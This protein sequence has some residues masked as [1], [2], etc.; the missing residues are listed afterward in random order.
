MGTAC[1]NDLTNNP[2]RCN[3]SAES[4][5]NLRSPDR[6]IHRGRLAVLMLALAIHGTLSLA[7]PDGIAAFSIATVAH[8]QQQEAPAEGENGAASQD[9]AEADGNGN[10]GKL[11]TLPPAYEDQL[12]RL[13]EVLGALHYLRNLCGSEE[14]QKWREEMQQLIDAEQP[15]E[16]S[17]AQMI[18]RFNRG[19]RGYAEIHH[20]CNQA[21]VE[22]ANDFLLQGA[23]LAAEIPN[24]YGR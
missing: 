9:G 2:A 19:F 4:G 15:D 21:A 14:G 12:M 1:L 5:R 17:R 23:K 11:K 6:L 20:E 8:A 10:A 7:G 3:P 22:A 24:R 16:A 13:S 18:A